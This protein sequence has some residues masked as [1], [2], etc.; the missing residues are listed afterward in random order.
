MW[1]FEEI[2]RTEINF[3]CIEP[4]LAVVLSFIVCNM[5]QNCRL[6]NS[7][8]RF[9][10]KR[11]IELKDEKLKIITEAYNDGILVINSDKEIVFTNEVIYNLLNCDQNNL[12]QILFQLEYSVGKKLTRYQES[13]KII[14]DLCYIINLSIENDREIALGVNIIDGVSLE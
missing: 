9:R 4:V 13:N 6:K 14:E 5:G 3:T 11:E 12:S 8:E 2:T 1:H 10:A 7:F